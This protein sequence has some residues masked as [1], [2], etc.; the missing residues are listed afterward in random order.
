MPISLKTAAEYF[1]TPGCTI[2]VGR[3]FPVDEP[4][5][6]TQRSR[7]EVWD[8]CP[9]GWIKEITCSRSTSKDCCRVTVRRMVSVAC[10]VSVML[11][12]HG[13]LKRLGPEIYVD[14]RFVRYGIRVLELH[15]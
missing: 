12:H 1:H 4:A 10:S 11:L 9:D 7:L 15:R 8:G 14:M 6:K 2:G 3:A 13:M 5:G